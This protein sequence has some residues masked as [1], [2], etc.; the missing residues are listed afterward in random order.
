MGSGGQLLSA[1]VQVPIWFPIWFRTARPCF[2]VVIELGSVLP[3][4]Q[5]Q[6]RSA[7][8]ASGRTVLGNPVE[9]LNL[10]KARG[11][12]P[13]ETMRCRPM[14]VERRVVGTWH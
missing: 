8:P 13:K 1:L 10:S 9:G 2:R 7:G 3:G 4:R 5:L 6:L 14:P 11:I 12:Q